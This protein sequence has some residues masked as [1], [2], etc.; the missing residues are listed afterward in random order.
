M[1]EVRS[2]IYDNLSSLQE[3]DKSMIEY[4]GNTL[5]MAAE[6]IAKYTD[7]MDHQTVV[8]DHYSSLLEIMGKS[9]DYKTM[10]KTLEGRAKMLG[11][12]ASVAKKTMEMYKD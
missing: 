6:E 10:G 8:L 4:Y 11:D 2:G 1:K 7:R 12:Q 9:N 3:L 5:D